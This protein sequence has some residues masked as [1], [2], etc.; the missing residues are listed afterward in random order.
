MK[1]RELLML[2]AAL[3]ATPALAQPK[4]APK[5]AAQ[6]PVAPNAPPIPEPDP[7]PQA[8]PNPAGARG[9][10]VAVV[11]GKVVS[12]DGAPVDGAT[13]LFADGKITAVGKGVAVPAGYK[14]IDAKGKWV[15]PGI[16]A[17]FSRLGIMEVELE[18]SAND[19][20]VRAVA[21]PAAA[22]AASAFDPAAIPI[23]VT[24]VE[25]VT[26]AAVAPIGGPSPI[27]GFGLTADLS[28]DD[29]SIS[30][31]KAFLYIEAGELGASRAGQSRM[32]LWPY[33]DAAFSDVAGVP[34]RY[35]SHSEGIVLRRAEAEALVPVLRGRIPIL[36]RVERASDIRQ[37]IALKRKRPELK[38]NLVG[39]SEAWRV[40][41]ELAAA[42]IGV[43]VSPVENLPGSFE[44][45]GSRADNAAIL[46]KAGVKVAIGSA[47]NSDEGHQ[48]RLT[49]QLAGNA[50]AHGMDWDD[51]FKAITSV[52]ADLYGLANAGRLRP[53]FVADLVVWDGDP[54][55]VMTN[56][57][58]VFIAGAPVA[59]D[60]RQT[61][62]RDR[63]LDIKGADEKP[64]QYR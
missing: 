40:A 26:R 28:G 64:F 1:R 29:D 55:E 10:R 20:R 9:V 38:I 5:P 3:L 12:N 45:L 21:I 60:S 7:G 11:G 13:V 48:V 49:P 25:G 2:G 42:G 34:M 62:L 44:T 18:D 31:Q 30:R 43:I 17:P 22:D 39:C 41:S 27:C 36:M 50:V 59:P 35:M 14:V 15:T 37:A 6:K 4:P 33:L 46:A 47:P 57:E 53:G 63:Y 61:R 54:L 23:A 32:T 51:A 52:P 19:A 58:A 24:R 16:F 8:A 56:A